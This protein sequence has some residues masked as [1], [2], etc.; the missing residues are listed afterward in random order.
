MPAVPSVNDEVIAIFRASGGDVPAPYDDPP[1][2]VLLHTIG[3]TSGREHV[4]PMRGLV[5]D[6]AVHVFATAHGSDRDPDWYRNIVATPEFD[7]ELGAETIPVRAS[8]VDGVERER[9]L[10]RWV[11]RVPQVASVFERTPRVVPVVRLDFRR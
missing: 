1:P 10:A 8:V 11:A 3:R 2:M 9:V 7:I 5:D 4:V 6:D